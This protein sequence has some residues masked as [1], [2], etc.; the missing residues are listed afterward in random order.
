MPSQSIRKSY[1]N[2]LLHFTWKME[3]IVA[4]HLC[5]RWYV[6]ASAIADS[7]T[8][9]IVYYAITIFHFVYCAP[10]LVRYRIRFT[11]DSIRTYGC[12]ERRK[13]NEQNE[14]IFW[15]TNTVKM[16]SFCFFLIFDFGYPNLCRMFCRIF[17][18]KFPTR[19]RLE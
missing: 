18:S 7:H 9:Y 8:A 12:T 14:F 16:T 19:Y 10:Q 2:F 6:L 5:A 13:Q 1:Y 3:P 4:T 11:R 15:K 17:L